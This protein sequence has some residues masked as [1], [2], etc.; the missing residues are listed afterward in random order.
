MVVD[1]DSKQLVDTLGNTIKTGQDAKQDYFESEQS[2]DQQLV[3]IDNVI[4]EFNTLRIGVPALGTSSFVI[5]HPVLGDIDSSTLAIDGGYA[6][7]TSYF[8]VI[9]N[10]DNYKEQFAHLSFIN[11][12]ATTASVNTTTQVVSF[13]AATSVLTSNVIAKDSLRLFTGFTITGTFTGSITAQV[14]G[15]AEAGSPTY[16]SV[17]MV[18]GIGVSGNFSILGSSVG[19]KLLSTDGVLQYPLIIKYY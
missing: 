10:N 11:S 1:F 9:N 2:P 18:S 13:G 19:Y 3:G 17:S 12:S 16:T 5:D 7:A 6:G 14:T 8:A 15:N 4:V